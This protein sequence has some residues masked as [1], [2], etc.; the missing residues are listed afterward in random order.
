METACNL[1]GDYNYNW[2]IY[3]KSQVDDV[4]SVAVNTISL[5]KYYM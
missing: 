4:A 2:S 5:S 1:I 3:C